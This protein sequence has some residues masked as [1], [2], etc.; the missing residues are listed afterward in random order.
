MQSTRVEFIASIIGCGQTGKSVALEGRT[1]KICYQ[2]R[3]VPICGHYFWDND[4]G[5]QI[6]CRMLGRDGGVTTRKESKL[7]ED[8]YNVGKC[9]EADAQNGRSIT[10]CTGDK[11]TNT[12]AY[13]FSSGS[14]CAEGE[15][16]GVY[17]DCGG[18]GI[19]FAHPKA[20]NSFC[21]GESKNVF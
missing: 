1:P 12:L 5:A 13:E 20:C 15:K 7:T 4:Y 6:F 14:S 2:D 21:S 3:F 19:H 17:I 10:E 16:S 9:S 18:R 8:A 11:N